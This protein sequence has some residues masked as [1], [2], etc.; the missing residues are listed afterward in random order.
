MQSVAPFTYQIGMRRAVAAAGHQ[1]I[2]LNGEWFA[3]DAS[4]VNSIIAAYDPLPAVQQEAL[5]TVAATLASK[6]GAG[7][8]YSNVLVAIDPQGRRSKIA[9]AAS[10]AQAILGGTSTQTWN[11]SRVWPPMTGTTGVPI[12]APQAMIDMAAAIGSYVMDLDLY[13]G[14]LAA[15]IMAATSAS[16]VQAINLTSGWPAS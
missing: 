5:A 4:A 8:M 1:L 2:L 6:L 12:G 14:S 11:S 3:D 9:E 10:L 16:A 13:A 15:Q 7:F